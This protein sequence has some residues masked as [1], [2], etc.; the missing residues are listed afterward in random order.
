MKISNITVD[1][2]E[3]DLF[4]LVNEVVHDFAKIDGLDII[5]LLVQENI[6]IEGTFKHKIKF[7][8]SI[9][10]SLKKLE[11]NILAFNID[12]IKCMNIRIA[13]FVVKGIFKVFFK[14]YKNIGIYVENNLV[15]IDLNLLSS[16]IPYV[17]FELEKLELCNGYIV[18]KINNMVYDSKKEAA[19]L[20]D[21]I[22]GSSISEH[23]ED[24]EV[25]QI[26]G[27]ITDELNENH[28][29][30][31]IHKVSDGYTTIRGTAEGV[32]EGK[33]SGIS[34]YALLIPDLVALI[35][36]LFKDKRV[37]KKDKLIAGIM[38][39][40][41]AIPIDIIPENIPVIGKVDDII[42]LFIGLDYLLNKIDEHIVIEN[43]EGNEDIIKLVAQGIEHISNVSTGGKI[44]KFIGLLDNLGM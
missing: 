19:N 9:K 6:F 5:S 13:N 32:I 39:T 29:C 1:I 17:N 27:N 2:K 8:F 4:G 26:E 12:M 33:F 40:Y 21:I 35:I 22:N 23:G 7:K 10:L 14:A 38:L 34:Q 37:H 30:A 36:R 31:A 20:E 25:L 3:N 44:K 41:V 16:L 28:A 18:T 42:I 24:D 11:N 15:Y 43:W